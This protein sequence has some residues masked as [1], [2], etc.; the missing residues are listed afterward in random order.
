MPSH[1][2]RWPSIRRAILRWYEEHGRSLAF[3]RTSD[4]YAV[5]VSETMAQQTQAARAADRWERF[6]SR[7]PTVDAL[8]AASPAEVLREWQGL[9][10]D[11][12]GLNLGRAAGVIVTRFGG[13]VPADVADLE[14]LPGVGPYTARAVAAIAFGVPVG[15]VDTNV[16]RV[17]GRIEGLDAGTVG[18]RG[19][20][21]NGRSMQALADEAVPSDR[22]AD[23]THALM[24]LGATVCRPRTPDC[25]ACPAAPWCH[26]L[27]SRTAIGGAVPVAAAAPTRGRRP[28]PRFATTNR[29][30]RGR[31]MDRLRAVPDADWVVVDGPIGDHDAT[32][33]ERAVAALESD[34]LVETAPGGRARLRLA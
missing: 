32:A 16:R 30:L 4:P 28:E 14:T 7:F 24:D 34:G 8:A 11:R 26:D 6:M 9:G 19:G 23:W 25:A 2:V 5:L 17:L 22:P 31:I 15:A 20:S 18:G 27:A 3:R 10:Y 1:P 12:R 33:V 21:S 29:W 13:R